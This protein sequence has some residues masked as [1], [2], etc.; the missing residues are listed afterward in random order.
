M[1]RLLIPLLIFATVG[2]GFSIVGLIR[3][4]NRRPQPII[5]QPDPAS[6]GLSV[7]EF[8]LVNHNGEPVDHSIFDGQVTILDFFFTHCPFICPTMTLAMQD[9]A[10][11]L[12]GTPVRF[13]S[14]SVDPANDTP[15]RLKQ[16]A[17]EKDIDLTR[18]TFLTGEMA[19]IERIARGSLGFAVGPDSDPSRTITLPS[20]QTMGNII[21]PSKLILIGPDR[22]VLGF[23]E[24]N[25]LEDTQQLLLRARVAAKSR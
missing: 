5:L 15:S 6:F 21:H 16:Y 14:I 17:T 12:S 4:M 1:R 10:R 24:S 3:T 18:W 19:V 13:A 25:S 2:L 22:K 23:Y 20:G 9:L 8:S 7:P 11:D